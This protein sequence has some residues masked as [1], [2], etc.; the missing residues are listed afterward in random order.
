MYYTLQFIDVEVRTVPTY[1]FSLSASEALA[2]VYYIFWNTF[3][4]CSS[5]SKIYLDVDVF[6]FLRRG[7]II[8]ISVAAGWMVVM[9]MVVKWE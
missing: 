2:N 6:G 3:P 7:H 9:V 4:Q 8:T 1:T 5:S